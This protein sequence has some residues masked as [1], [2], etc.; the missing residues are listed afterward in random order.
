MQIY[1][2]HRGHIKACLFDQIWSRFQYVRTFS[3]LSIN[4]IS[5]E[6]INWDL[7][8]VLIWEFCK[9]SNGLL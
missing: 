3:F 1:L 2:V 4:F 6:N 9:E 8:T 5:I 7:C